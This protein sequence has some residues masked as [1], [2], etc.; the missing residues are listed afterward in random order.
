VCRSCS[1]AFAVLAAAQT[2]AAVT[3][4]QGFNGSSFSEEDFF[5][6]R[7]KEQGVVR[8]CNSGWSIQDGMLAFTE[9]QRRGQLPVLE[10]CLPFTPAD[11]AGGAASCNRSCTTTLQQLL[12]GKFEAKPLAAIPDMQ[13][14]IRQH[15]SIVCRM[16]L[17]S[18][19][20]PFFIKFPR[21][22]YEKPGKHNDEDPCTPGR[23]RS[24]ECSPS[25]QVA[26]H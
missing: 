16:Q 8:D 17:F 21:G 20:R 18:D 12:Y 23:T 25:H 24:Y 7:T 6:C 4:Q 22:V 3:L 11:N 26:Q 15:G 14:H 9:M 2:A 5:F 19:I 1:V 13:R 10:A